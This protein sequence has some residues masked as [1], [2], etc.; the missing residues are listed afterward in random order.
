ML[1]ITN[2]RHGTTIDIEGTPHMVLSY[3]HSKMGRGGAVVRTKLKNLK[4]GVTFEKTFHGNDKVNAAHL[5]ERACTYLYN[6]GSVFTFMDA[7]TFEQC[8]MTKEA[9]GMALMYLAE[10][11][12]VKM[13]FY[14]GTAIAIDLPIKMEF[15]V[16]HTEPGVRGDT[17]QGG[18]KPAQIETGA[19]ITV[20]LFITTG[21]VIRVDTRDGGYLERATK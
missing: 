2:L 5:D 12:P 3:A 14:D 8:T 20:P 15:T 7:T 17:A 10:G 16:T 9:L 13:M 18:S 1:S 11:S 6:D 4:N 19:T 21:D